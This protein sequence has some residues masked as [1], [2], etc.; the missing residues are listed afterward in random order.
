MDPARFDRISKLFAERRLSRRQALATGAIAGAGALAA[1]Q[2]TSASAQEA[3]SV[4]EDATPVPVPEGADTAK[5]TYL[6]VQSFQSGSIAPTAGADGRYTVTLDH[7]LGQTIY[8]GDRP[9]RDV[10]VSPTE[11]FLDGLGFSESNP[12]NAALLL[13]T[14]PGET[15]IAVV[16]LYN[17][18][19][20]VATHT[21]TYDVQV[22]ERW[23]D[24]LDLGL[25]EEPVDLAAITTSFGAAHLLI[26]DCTAQ[27]I[28]CLDK[29]TGAQYGVL[30]DEFCY[31]YLLCIPCTPYGHS[32]PDRCS[33][34]KYWN[35]QCTAAYGPCAADGCYADFLGADALC[36]DW[37]D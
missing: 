23:E 32:Q 2:L 6:F 33:V 31:N 13:E 29:A 21:A 20:D 12:P 37:W 9:S 24:E 30:G 34:R 22:L 14:T 11:Q 4:T 1:T 28:Y 19:Y 16:E 17:P 36:P 27:D 7:G 18:T 25:S 15:E 3:T 8:F 10:G 5:V 26:D 35:A